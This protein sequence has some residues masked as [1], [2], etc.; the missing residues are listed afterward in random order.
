MRLLSKEGSEESG[1]PNSI[2]L[3][4]QN[5][6]KCPWTLQK[7][8]WNAGET[9]PD[10]PAFADKLETESPGPDVEGPFLKMGHH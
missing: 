2:F 7:W 6:S 8:H 5:N 4:L 10:E 1:N 9:A 3:K